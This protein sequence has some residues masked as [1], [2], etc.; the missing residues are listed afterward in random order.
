MHWIG[1]NALNNKYED[2]LIAYA[3]RER[4]IGAL[5]FLIIKV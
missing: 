5:L 2:I 4:K 1:F 3:N